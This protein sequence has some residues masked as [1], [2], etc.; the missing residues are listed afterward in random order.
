MEFTTNAMAITMTIRKK[1]TT[2]MGRP[3]F[4]LEGDKNQRNWSLVWSTAIVSSRFI[5]FA[6]CSSHCRHVYRVAV[7]SF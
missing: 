7:H 1:T 2:M 4:N 5:C 3:T 6:N